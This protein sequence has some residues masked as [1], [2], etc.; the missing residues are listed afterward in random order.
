MNE[1]LSFSNTKLYQFFW[2]TV[3]LKWYQIFCNTLY[4]N[5]DTCQNNMVIYVKYLFA[6]NFLEFIYSNSKNNFKTISLSPSDFLIL[7]LLVD[8]YIQEVQL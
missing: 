1:N 7:I 8:S 4:N 6:V 2:N 3:H 5:E